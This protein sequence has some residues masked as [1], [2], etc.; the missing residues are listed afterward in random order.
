MHAQEIV[1]PAA[2]YIGC[3]MT[4][5]QTRA[6]KSWQWQPTSLPSQGRKGRTWQR[7]MRS[8]AQLV[9]PFVEPQSRCSGHF[10]L[11]S[12]ARQLADTNLDATQQRTRRPQ[13]AAWGLPALAGRAACPKSLAGV[14]CCPP[15]QRAPEQLRPSPA[16]PAPHQISIMARL[17]QRCPASAC[18]GD[19]TSS[20]LEHCTWRRAAP[21]LARAARPQQRRGWPPWSSG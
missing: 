1:S 11:S 15:L 10:A 14:T 5:T 4:A 8:T 16:A 6:A 9:P 12:A 13:A 20:V 2:W 7:T 19:G 3:S 17:G 21:R 18:H